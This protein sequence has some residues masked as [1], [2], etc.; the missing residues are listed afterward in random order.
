MTRW[1][2]RGYRPALV[3]YADGGLTP[4][5]VERLHHHLARCDRCAGELAALRVAPALLRDLPVTDPGEEFWRQ[6][7][8]AIGRAV[9]QLPT[10]R[11]GGGW[12]WRPLGLRFAPVAWAVAA[13]LVMTIGM[14][15]L[16]SRYSA[17]NGAAV[18]LGALDDD[19]LHDVDEMADVIAGG[20]DL[21]G[22][23]AERGA[24]VPGAAL[25]ALV[26][27]FLQPPQPFADDNNEGSSESTG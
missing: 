10:P 27:T 26:G 24:F 17:W 20:D 4:A 11:R 6:Q 22:Q 9:R 2:C 13:V 19:T 21:V 25:E 12:Q 3:D 23:L 16:A 14:T 5:A 7:R 1:R 8:W 15:R 18:S